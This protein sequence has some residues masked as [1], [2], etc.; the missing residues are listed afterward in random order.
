MH[1]QSLICVWLFVT[2]DCMPPVSSVHVI[3]QARILECVAIP[4]LGELSDPGIELVSPALAGRLFTTRH[5]G[6]PVKFY[7]RCKLEN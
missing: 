5:L 2:I 1:A 6:S 4:N 7:L 3:F